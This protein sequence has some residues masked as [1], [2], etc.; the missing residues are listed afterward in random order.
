MKGTFHSV[1]SYSINFPDARPLRSPQ[2]S[3]NNTFFRL[4]NRI[5][6]IPAQGEGFVAM[7]NTPGV[8]VFAPLRH[9]FG[10]SLLQ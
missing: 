10:M 7:T 3:Y 2:H 1:A 9:P 8:H 4:A 6:P 5:P